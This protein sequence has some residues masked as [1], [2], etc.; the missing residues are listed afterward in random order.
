MSIND[1]HVT[2]DCSIDS[3]VSRFMGEPFIDEKPVPAN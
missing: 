3:V 1:D 2:S